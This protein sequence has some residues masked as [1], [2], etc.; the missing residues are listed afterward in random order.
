M[1]F[2]SQ[3]TASLIASSVGGAIGGSFVIFGVNR[4]FRH[5]SE[6]ALRALHVEI[7]ANRAAADQM[8][9]ALAA[10]GPK[11]RFEIGK[12]DPGW[13]RRSI[14]DSQLPFFVQLVDREIL[15]LISAAYFTLEAV[16]R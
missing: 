6:A 12:A 7:D 10:G 1:G 16:R 15:T 3:L 13:F 8:T 2:W 4:Q 9:Q 11:D 14:W 5:Q